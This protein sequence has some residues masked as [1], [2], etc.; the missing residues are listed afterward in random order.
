MRREH[1]VVEAF[2]GRWVHR[3]LRIDIQPCGAEGALAKR[4]DQRGLFDAAAAGDVHHDAFRAEGLQHACVDNAGGP[5]AADAGDR[6]EVDRGGH[7]REIVEVAVRRVGLPARPVVGHIHVEARRAA[8]DRMADRTEP[9]DAEAP[10]VHPAGQ[11]CAPDPLPF[12]GAHI[13]LG[14][15]DAARRSHHKGE[16]EVRDITGRLVRRV[17]HTDAALPGLCEVDVLVAV[18]HQHDQFE[19]RQRI[20]QRR[21][22]T[23]FVGEQRTHH[24]RSLLEQRRPILRITVVEHRVPV[25]ECLQRR[26][27]VAV[28]E[29]DRWLSG[30][31]QAGAFGFRCRSKNSMYSS[32]ASRCTGSGPKLPSAPG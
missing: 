6:E 20:H 12:A 24:W 14:P 9:D 30:L 4:R 10:S 7:C 19:C 8:R 18:G 22:P 16:R 15:G 27:P 17:G 32:N 28:D 25:F 11:R 13:A 21:L 26:L 1:D 31:H 23:A 3:L 2:E 5:R 29:Q